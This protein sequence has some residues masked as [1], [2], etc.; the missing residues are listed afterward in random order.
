MSNWWFVENFTTG[1]PLTQERYPALEFPY[2][3]Y[4][5]DQVVV[6]DVAGVS[7]G[8]GMKGNDVAYDNGDPVFILTGTAVSP[9]LSPIADV[10][11]VAMECDVKFVAGSRGTDVGLYVDMMNNVTS[12]P[13]LVDI[14]VGFT[15][16]PLTSWLEWQEAA[17]GGVF[18]VRRSFSSAY[19]ELPAAQGDGLWHH[20]RLVVQA[21]TITSW[22]YGTYGEDVFHDPLYTGGALAVASDGYIRLWMDGTLV[23]EIVSIPLVMNFEGCSANMTALHSYEPASRGTEAFVNRLSRLA[24]QIFDSTAIVDN[25]RVGNLLSSDEL[26]TV[27]QDIPNYRT[28]KLNAVVGSP[29]FRNGWGRVKT[30]L[31][32]NPAVPMQ[33][34]L[35]NLT[36]GTSMGAGAEV[37][38]ATPVSQEFRVELPLGTN[39]YRLQVGASQEGADLFAMAQL[40]LEPGSIPD[41]EIP[42]EEVPSCPSWWKTYDGGLACVTPTGAHHLGKDEG[43]PGGLQWYRWVGITT[44]VNG[45]EGPIINA[46]DWHG[47]TDPGIQGYVGWTGVPGATAYRV[48]MYNCM[49]QVTMQLFDPHTQNTTLFVD[50]PSDA[51][52][53]VV[54]QFKDVP[55]SPNNFTNPWGD[56][57]VSTHE[58]VFE[59]DAAGTTWTLCCGG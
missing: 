51:G 8:P 5:I 10:G 18:G 39:R 48:Y 6:D 33:A 43:D 32:S 11:Q 28:I 24:F 35:M 9:E 4:Q 46:G 37:E 30:E 38:S 49:N 44:I 15:D 59:D 22:V 16:S 7:D 25:L 56:D 19:P 47:D 50:T 34:R 58:C 53:A 45:T 27:W 26:P 13:T 41:P 36:T 1:A 21:G 54:V 29:Y 31:W 14:R 57:V 17:G 23:E 12:S 52:P 40:L 55:A 2:P 20:I 42:P 3:P